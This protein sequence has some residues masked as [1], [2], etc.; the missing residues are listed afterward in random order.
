MSIASAKLSFC[1][2]K[3]SIEHKLNMTHEFMQFAIRHEWIRVFVDCIC[4]EFIPNWWCILFWF[5]LFRLSLCFSILVYL[6]CVYKWPFY[7]L[8][9]DRK[10]LMHHI[11]NTF[12]HWNAIEIAFMLLYTYIRNNAALKHHKIDQCRIWVFKLEIASQFHFQVVLCN[13]TSTA[14]VDVNRI[15]WMTKGISVVVVAAAVTTTI[16]G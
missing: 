1:D 15:G 7:V 8:I 3:R 12:Y 11:V 2:R 9:V 14:T 4:N 16:S 6:R 13:F 10:M 5:F